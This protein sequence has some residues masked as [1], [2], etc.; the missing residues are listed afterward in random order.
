MIIEDWK[1]VEALLNEVLEL[2]PAERPGF[3]DR[4]CAGDNGIRSEIEALLACEPQVTE[5]LRIPAISFSEGLIDSV[6]D[7]LAGQQIGRYRIVRELGR[8]GMGAVYLAE[9]TDE[10]VK[11]LFALK[12]LKRELNTADLRRRFIHERQILAGLEH[13][14]ITRLLDLGSTSDGVPYFAMEYVD[15]VPIDKYCRRHELTID[16]VLELFGRICDGVAFAHRKLVIHR[17]LKPSNILV[18]RDGTPKLLDFGIAKL[19]TPE[20]EESS[21]HT[22]TGLGAMSVN[23]ASPE[24]LRGLPVSTATDIY[25]LGVVLYELLAGQRPFHTQS[26]NPEEIIKSVCETEPQRPSTVAGQ[27]T[28]G[29]EQRAKGEEGSAER[30]D[31]GTK[32]IS[33]TAFRNPKLL[34]GDLD[35]IVLMALRK[36][37]ERRYS[38]VEELSSDIRRQLEGRP[39]IATRD[40]FSYRAG[41]FIKRHRAGVAATLLILLALI[42]GMI[43]TAWQA[44]AARRERDKAQYINTFLRDM[45][46]AAAPQVKGADIKVVDV[47]NEASRRA[48]TELSDKPEVMADVLLTLGKTYVS[49]GW[50]DKAETDLRAS[51]DASLKANGE[52]HPT[53]ATSMGWLGMALAFKSK[54][55]E[56]AQISRRAV[57]LLRQLYPGGHEELGVAL[58]SLGM[59]LI[60][61]GDAKAAV[62]QLQEAVE[63][64]KKHLGENHGFYIAALTMLA[65]SHEVSGDISGAESLYRQAIEVGRRVEG[66]YRIYLAQSSGL[67]GELLTNKGQYPEAENLLRQ[68]ETIYREVL[69]DSNSSIGPTRM[70]LGRLYYVQGSYGNAAEEYRKA[71]EDLQPYF[72]REHPLTLTTLASLGLS[73]TRTGKAAEAEPY[74]REALEIRRKVLPPGDALISNAE[75]GLGECL[76]A[77]GHF[78]E[79]ETLLLS[80]YAGLKA[81]LGE[82]A[83]RTVE[84]RQRLA[85][86]YELW[87][88]PE[89]AAQYRQ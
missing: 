60:V 1:K 46:G 13:P 80:G 16:K 49:L 37:P 19:L 64:I 67:L 6:K 35:N 2:S 5:F 75:S 7:E 56:G 52:R 61:S 28:A 43:T 48:R 8:G 70:E 4:A 79:A 59:N 3:L 66:R 89:L 54:G 82:Q 23:Y 78:A 26:R 87:G 85:K 81:K 57:E 68:S 45:L 65:R 44:R 86:L 9:R 34:R 27:S 33:R 73:L 50:Y 40:T 18:T 11:Q 53:T 83:Q 24:Q 69:G 20:F 25:S 12:L 42:G 71:L 72:P 38:S 17:D 41:K 29:K 36:E 21:D 14:H 74:L 63:V 32:A 51:I 62:P 15:G 10:D 76:T 84:A 77:Q 55:A 47:L 88:K 58:H 31:H 22:A 30:R 39:V